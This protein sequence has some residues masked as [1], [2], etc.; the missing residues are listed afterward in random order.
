MNIKVTIFAQIPS[1]SAF[2]GRFPGRLRN[3]EK[4][5]QRNAVYFKELVPLPS[6]KTGLG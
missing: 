2:Y 4:I 1:F 6:P 3:S 5:F